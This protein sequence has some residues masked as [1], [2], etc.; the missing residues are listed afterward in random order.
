MAAKYS[1]LAIVT[2]IASVIS[3]SR[4]ASG[5]LFLQRPAGIFAVPPIQRYGR[6]RMIVNSGY[7]NMAFRGEQCLWPRAPP[8]IRF[9]TYSPT[10]ERVR[11]TSRPVHRAY[12][13]GAVQN[14]VPYFRKLEKDNR[15][16][17]AGPSTSSL[18]LSA[19]EVPTKIRN[20]RF[21]LPTSPDARHEFMQSTM[22]KPGSEQY[23]VS[24]PLATIA[25]PSTNPAL[26]LPG[27]STILILIGAHSTPLTRDLR[28]VGTCA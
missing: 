4:S 26:S 27:R 25:T 19:G 9:P 28:V 21:R 2:S 3:V 22:L 11:C 7:D 1:H 5:S 23:N 10:S 20:N 24:F 18:V 15:M 13:G 16:T 12:L 8:A 17:S 14:L 6:G